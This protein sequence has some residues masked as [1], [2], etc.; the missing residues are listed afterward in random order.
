MRDQDADVESSKVSHLD[1]ECFL[2]WYG[3]QIEAGLGQLRI[4]AQSLGPLCRAED[5]ELFHCLADNLARLTED[6]LGTA[7]IRFSQGSSNHKS[8]PPT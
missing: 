2:H 3:R 1:L 5:A 7:T 8:D 4:A 6:S